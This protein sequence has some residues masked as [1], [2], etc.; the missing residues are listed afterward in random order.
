MKRFLALLALVLVLMAGTAGMASADI[1]DFNSAPPYSLITLAVDPVNDQQNMQWSGL[2][3]GHLYCDTSLYDNIISFTSPTYVNSFQINGESWEGA[4]SSAF[5]YGPM[6]IKAFNA[7]GGI[8]WSTTVNFAGD[9][10]PDYK[11]WGCW[12]TVDVSTAGVSSIIFSI[13]PLALEA[14]PFFYPSI[15]NLVITSAVPIPAS[16]W[17]LGSGL[18]ALVG[19]RRK[20]TR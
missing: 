1:L 18:L 6:T 17:L 3:G 2:G 5:I 12:L 9:P 4:N 14:G 20:F 15:D 10:E 16:V 13:N 11:Y 19:L 8:V 7:A